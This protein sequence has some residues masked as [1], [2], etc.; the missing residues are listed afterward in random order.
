M[1]LFKVEGNEAI[2]ISYINTKHEDIVTLPK[3]VTIDGKEY[4][5]KSVGNHVDLVD[6]RQDALNQYI[7]DSKDAWKLVIP[8]TIEYIWPDAFSDNCFTEV[9]FEEGSNLQEIADYAFSCNHNLSTI[10]LPDSLERIKSYAFNSCDLLEE[11]NIPKNVYLINHDAFSECQSLKRIIVDKENK[12]Y[13][14]RGDSNSIIDTENNRLII[15]C[16]GTVIPESV[17]E[18]GFQSFALTEV[19]KVH[20]PKSVREICDCAFNGSTVSEMTFDKDGN[21]KYICDTAF[22]WCESLTKITLPA[23]LERIYSTNYSNKHSLF[24]NCY[25]LVSVDFEPH[26]KLR[27]IPV[28]CFECCHRLKRVTIPENVEE[29]G[30]NIFDSCHALKEVRVL[31]LDTEFN[32]DAFKGM[33]KETIIYAKHKNA[34]R[35]RKI[36]DEGVRVEEIEDNVYV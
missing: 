18:I 7:F 20:F 33:R 21:L 11:I 15:A 26:C 1:F 4:I 29:V 27:K 13:D 16:S 25:N 31:S 9:E 19:D 8:N 35:I 6:F 3:T 22:R 34:E 5:V 30:A 10:K 14:S 17:E 24:F 23:S 28:G 36:V 12:Y 32:P 2:I